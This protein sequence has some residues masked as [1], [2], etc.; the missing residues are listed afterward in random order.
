MDDKL[1]YM[2]LLSGAI[3]IASE[4]HLG[5]KDKAGKPYILHPLRVATKLQDPRDQIVAVLHDVFEDCPGYSTEQFR[6]SFG[7]E[8]CD[9]LDAITKI[10][11]EDYADYLERVRQ[12]PIAARV[13][14]EDL[15]DNSDLT[16][17]DNPGKEDFERVNKYAA[18]LV[19]LGVE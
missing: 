9:A 17:L 15:K 10:E 6:D 11:G 3:V 12:N 5:Q 18:A 8:I 1:D 14:I 13:K 2:L 7:D 19:F 4:A 16:R